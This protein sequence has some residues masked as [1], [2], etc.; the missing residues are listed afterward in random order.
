ML[1]VESSD[2]FEYEKNWR[3]K[4]RELFVYHL[5]GAEMINWLCDLINLQK[6]E[7]CNDSGLF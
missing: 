1:D 6:D 2:Q 7:K 3:Q 5:T 4:E